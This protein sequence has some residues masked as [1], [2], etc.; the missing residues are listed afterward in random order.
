MDIQSP[1]DLRSASSV[2]APTYDGWEVVHLP[3]KAIDGI[4]VHWKGWTGQ[5]N[6]YNYDRAKKRGIVFIGEGR[7]KTVIHP[8]PSAYSAVHIGEGRVAFENCSIES[9]VPG[10][11]I[12]WTSGFGQE[13]VWLTLR[14]VEARATGPVKWG[15][16]THNTDDHLEE[17]DIYAAQAREHASYR[18]GHAEKLSFWKKVHVHDAGAED[19]KGVAR[20]EEKARFFKDMMIIREDCVYADWHQSHSPMGGGFVCQG[21]ASHVVLRRCI[22]RPSARQPSK[23]LMLDDS[24]KLLGDDGEP[25]P[26]ARSFDIHTGTPMTVANNSPEQCANGWV[27][28]E[29]CGVEGYGGQAHTP[30]VRVGPQGGGVHKLALGVLLSGSGVYGQNTKVELIGVERGK[31]G[32]EKIGV[33]GCN[34]P[35]IQTAMRSLG[36]K[37]EVESALAIHGRPWSLVSKGFEPIEPVPVGG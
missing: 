1:T 27:L 32:R 8:A 10:G 21:A 31:N 19:D 7:G 25:Y 29:E 37:A 20:P 33:A 2:P 11:T 3:A 28:I 36:F 16:M 23:A 9:G 5:R 6:V 15:L 34:T 22:F 30:M 26:N 24:Y 35:G 14:D 17:V 18:H 13:P 4:S 12:L